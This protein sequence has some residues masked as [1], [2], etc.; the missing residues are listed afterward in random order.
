MLPK[1]GAL[2]RRAIVFDLAGFGHADKPY[3]FDYSLTATSRRFGAALSQLGVRRVHLVLHDIGG[4]IG[5]EWAARHP[6]QLI[7]ATLLNTG[8]LLG[9]QHHDLAKIWRSPGGEGFMESFTRESFRGGTQMGQSRP[10]P[11]SFLDRTYDDFDRATRCA[12]LKGYRA[13]DADDPDAF[14][15]RQAEVLKKRPGR[16]ALVVWGDEDPYLAKEIADR[17]TKAFPLAQVH[18]FPKSGHWAFIDDAERARNLVLPFV[19]CLPTGRRDRIRLR[20]SPR[21]VRSGKLTRF[22]VAATVVARGLAR[23]VCGAQVR[24]GR[25]VVVTNQFGQASVRT[26]LRRGR[27]V[28]R[29]R[30]NDLRSAARVV[31]SR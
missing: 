13:P 23:P 5:M 14:A 10:L 9:Y 3:R 21:R 17:Q 26:R 18:H 22:R 16:P 25:R 2:G 27:H 30:K 6:S 15:R 19:R 12:V 7:S 29:A 11:N 4:P 20:V 8:V 24:I 1:V 31:R 28:V